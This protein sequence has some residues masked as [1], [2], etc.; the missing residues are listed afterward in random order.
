MKDINDPV[1]R[2]LVSKEGLEKLFGRLGISNDHRIVLYGDFNNWFAAFTFWVFKY[3]GVENVV[4]MN[5]RPKKE[6]RHVPRERAGRDDSRVPRLRAAGAP[7]E[8]QGPR[9][10][11]GP[12][13]V[14]GRDPRAA[15]VPDGARAARRAHPGREEH[16]VG[17]GRE[18]RGRDGQVARGPPRAVPGQGRDAGQGGHRVLQD[19]GAV[20]P[21]VVRAQV[22]PRI[23]EREELRRL[24]DGVGQHHPESDRE[25]GNSLT[26]ITR[27]LLRI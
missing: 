19:R 12:E 20:V 25:V 18:R 17:A 10:R 14:L 15:G 16:P 1:T 4:L 23:P 27:T 7:D 2:D 11:P 3:Y 8:G 24:V 22:P 26:K 13:G 5:S 21:H 6:R 9:G